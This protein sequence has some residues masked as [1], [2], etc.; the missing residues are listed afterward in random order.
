MQLPSYDSQFVTLSQ[1]KEGYVRRHVAVDI[2]TSD[3]GYLE[4]IAI[5]EARMGKK[6]DIMPTLVANDPLRAVIFPD[7]IPNKNPDLRIEGVLW[8]VERSSDSLKINNLK[9]AIDEGSNPADCVII[10][11]S[12]DIDFNF[13]V[14]VVKGRFKDHI[15]L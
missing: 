15:N 3:Y 10:N 5:E 13:M 12:D 14:R 2:Y 8:E 1:H 7:L 6:V 11:L 4:E 9:H